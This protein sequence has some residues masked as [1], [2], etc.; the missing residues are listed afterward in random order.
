MTPG[1][2]APAG[3]PPIVLA[4]Q[5]RI[6][7]ALLE[8]AGVAVTVEPAHVDEEEIRR[9]MRGDGAPP[10]AVAEA[11]AQTKALR[12]SARHPGALVVGCDQVLECGG[13]AYDKPGDRAQ[14]AD[15]LRA[16]SGRT[17]RLVSAA[18]VAR[19]GVRIWHAVD[20]ARLTMRVLGP[21]FIDAYLDAAGEHALA[22]VGAYQ[23]EGLGAQLFARVE[24]DYFTVL[25]LPLLP[26]LACLR[27]QGALR[28]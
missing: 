12:I 15:Q 14:A 4:S 27:A 3:A 9:A 7:R 5:S 1:L 10:A 11:L 24:G 8:G 20:E 18:V 16:L 13:T 21:A 23:L 22:S 26:L 2:A 17:H 19:G 25:G 28:E 6:R